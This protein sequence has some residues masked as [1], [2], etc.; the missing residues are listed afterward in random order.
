MLFLFRLAV[1]IRYSEFL[2]SDSKAD[3]FLFRQVSN[4]ADCIK[5]AVDFVSP[6]N[7]ARC[8]KLTKEF[9]EENDI[10]AWK[11]DVLQLRTMMWH[12]WVSCQRFTDAAP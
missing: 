8:A 7:I 3:Q 2:L 1:L 9:R 10:K 12:A 5:I 6:E 4:A 11:E